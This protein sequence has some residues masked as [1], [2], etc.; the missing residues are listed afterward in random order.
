M[1]LFAKGI[2]NNAVI[3]TL[4]ARGVVIVEKKDDGAMHTT[5]V[6][7]SDDLLARK[8]PV[9]NTDEAG[10]S[11]CGSTCCLSFNRTKGDR[12]QQVRMRNSKYSL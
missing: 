12:G 2:A 7:A 4:G 8:L 3:V 1:S 10:E 11:F 6:D 5:I 9:K